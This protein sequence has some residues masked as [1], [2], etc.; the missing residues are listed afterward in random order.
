MRHTQGLVAFCLAFASVM[1]IANFAVEPAFSQ[2]Y[3]TVTSYQ[4][5][6]AVSFTT[7]TSFLTYVSTQLSR[8]ASLTYITTVFTTSTSYLT[9]VSVMF[10]SSTSVVGYP[11]PTPNFV[12]NWA[13]LAP[14]NFSI[15]F[16]VFLAICAGLRAKTLQVCVFADG[17]ANLVS[18]DFHCGTTFSSGHY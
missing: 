13:S 5:Y 9:Y 1:A 4:T 3:T 11:A 16:Y 17:S 7:S 14:A 2:T 10:T 8:S 12:P 18:V 15:I 6:V